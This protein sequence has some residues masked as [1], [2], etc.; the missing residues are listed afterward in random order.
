MRTRPDTVS[1][2]PRPP[3]LRVARAAAILLAPALLWLAGLASEASSFFPEFYHQWAPRQGAWSTYHVKDA[4]GEEADLTFAVVGE[5]PE[6]LWMEIRTSSGGVPSVAA[7]LLK[8]DPTEDANIVSVRAKDG[9][10]PAVEIDRAALERLRQQGGDR[11]GQRAAAIGPTF[12]RLEALPEEKVK[13]GRR[14]LVCRRLRIVAEEGRS[15]E[16]WLSDEVAPFGVV[17]LASGEEE[18]ALTD[19]GKGAKPS[20]AGPFLRFEV[21]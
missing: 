7:Y 20:L 3:A 1:L 15:A 8:G 11:F 13:V 14:T 4:R 5:G 16:V 19:F 21:P 6:G 17:R 12:G 10:G 18:V 9:D 2:P